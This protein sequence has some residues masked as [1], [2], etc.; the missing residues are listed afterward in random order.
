MFV[1]DLGQ[2][3]RHLPSLQTGIILGIGGGLA[4]AVHGED[5]E[6]TKRWAASGMLDTV[7]EAGGTLGGVWVQ[8][9]GAVGTYALSRAIGNPRAA[10]LGVDLVRGQIV[11][12]VL[13]EG[14]KFAVDRQRPDGGHFSFPSGH[15][16][17]AFTTATVLERRFGLKVGIPAFAAAAF[18]GGSRLQAN[19]HYL[20]DVAFGAAI[21]IVSGRSAT[22]GHGSGTFAM[23]PLVAPATVGLAFTYRARP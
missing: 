20:S 22:V 4:T 5:A 15:T 11:N 7:F 1:R 18:V 21:G 12:A 23:S 17:S 3:F 13:T 10:L 16:S 6:I 19:Q 2:D 8:L 9:G 14:I